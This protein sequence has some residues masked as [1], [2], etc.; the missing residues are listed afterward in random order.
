VTHMPPRMIHILHR[1][2]RHSSGKERRF[3]RK[4]NSLCPFVKRGKTCS[5]HD[6]ITQFSVFDMIVA[7]V[8]TIRIG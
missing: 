7:G 2:R 6:N 4:V 8:F 5:N 3:V 1:A